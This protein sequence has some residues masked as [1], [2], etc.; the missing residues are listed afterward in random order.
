MA[1]SGETLPKAARSNKKQTEAAP[2]KWRIKTWPKMAQWCRQSLKKLPKNGQ[3]GPEVAKMVKRA[4]MT[5]MTKMIK[6]APIVQKD[7]VRRSKC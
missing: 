6:R 3:R 5:K 2:K 1:K 4:K 7:V